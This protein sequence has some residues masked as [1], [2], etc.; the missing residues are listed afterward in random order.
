VPRSG[1]RDTVLRA[2]VAHIAK[3]GPDS[4]SLRQVAADAGVSHQ[5][6]Y[7]HFGDRKAVFQ[8]IALEGY[9]RLR[10]AL[11]RVGPDPD[12][13]RRLLD[14]GEQYVQFALR[15]RGHF[16]V[17]FR[18]DLCPITDSDELLVAADEA[19][20][21]LRRMVAEVLGDG[22][23]DEHVLLRAATMWSLAHGLSNLL[24]DGSMESKV[25]RSGSRAEFVRAVLDGA[26]LAG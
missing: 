20:E 3:H 17:M 24:I 21:V 19:F 18:S 1:L 26:D 15:H 22:V 12:P 11:E 2:A 25:P 5:A 23:D 9:V 10:R 7:H 6:P 16:R 13:Q 14:M 8:A 4:L